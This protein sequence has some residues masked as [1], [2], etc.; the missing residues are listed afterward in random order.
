MVFPF[1]QEPSVFFV[2]A[3]LIAEVLFKQLLNI[4]DNEA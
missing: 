2:V 4:A 3:T 1:K